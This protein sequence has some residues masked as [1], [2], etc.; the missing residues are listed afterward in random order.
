MDSKIKY[1]LEERLIDFAIIIT[2]AVEALPNTGS[3]IILPAN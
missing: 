1:D 2:D 3:E